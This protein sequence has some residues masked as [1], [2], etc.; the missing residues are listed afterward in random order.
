MYGIIDHHDRSQST[1]TEAS[2]PFQVELAII[3]GLS[4]VDIQLTL[5]CLQNAPSAP[6][7]ARG[8]QANLDL[9]LAWRRE[10][11]LIVEGGHAENLHCGNT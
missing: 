10:P 11:K 8:A 5:H 3:G 4:R 6:N 9:M 1:A 2:N 7:M